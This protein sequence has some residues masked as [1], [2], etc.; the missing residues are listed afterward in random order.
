MQDAMGNATEGY[1]DTDLGDQASPGASV[2]G[3]P[4]M[5][6]G[7]RAAAAGIPELILNAGEPAVRAYREFL[8]DA[9][10]SAGTRRVYGQRV[11]WFF[12][13]A[14]DRGTTLESVTAADVAAAT[15][16]LSRSMASD[17]R[18]ALRCHY[19]HL[20]RAAIVDD[21][22]VP[23]DPR[24]GYGPRRS[25]AVAHRAAEPAGGEG[26]AWKARAIKAIDARLAAVTLEISRL[27]GELLGLRFARGLLLSREAA[28]MLPGRGEHA[29]MQEASDAR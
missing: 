20:V 6:V 24:G 22:P 28:V 4:R 10:L 26:D 2:L 13:G 12:R 29:G 14:A 18:S 17:V 7:K 16:S 15:A 11:R 25:P 5:P 8:D 19:R 21:N 3:D 23:R 1:C 27:E 9:G